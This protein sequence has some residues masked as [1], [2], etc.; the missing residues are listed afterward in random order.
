[1]IFNLYSF[2]ND[3]INTKPTTCKTIARAGCYSEKAEEMNHEI[4]FADGTVVPSLGQGTWYMGEDESR[5]TDEV[6]ALQHGIELGMTVIDTAEMY[7]DGGA[8]IVTGEALAGRRDKVFLI[9]KVLPSNA[10]LRGTIE[11]CERSLRRLRTDHIDLYL[12]HWRGRYSLEETVEAMH[13]LQQDGK[14]GMWGVSNFDVDD[15]E[16]LYQTGCTDCATNEVLYNLSRRGVEYDLLPWSQKASM[17]VIAYS[18]IEQGRILNNPTL[19][20]IAHRHGKTP[21]QI[22][23]AWVLSHKGV[24]P[25]PKAS[26]IKHV[27]QNAESLRIELT[28]DDMALLERAFPA[29]KTKIPLEMI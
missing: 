8:E 14:I 3:K 12:L 6:R 4:K 19:A 16:E 10:S 11:A 28:H 24:M 22:A 21:A 27:E 20:N 9:S 17:P 23:L 15:M 13:R 5:R 29:P 1:M 26:N 7:A 18:P 2:N 25:I